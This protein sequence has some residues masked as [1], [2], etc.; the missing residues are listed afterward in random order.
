METAESE[1]SH[2]AE[3]TA[4]AI[5]NGADRVLDELEVTERWVGEIVR[6]HPIACFLGAIVTGYVIGRVARRV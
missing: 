2:G 1:A 4:D 6:T 5:G 3:T